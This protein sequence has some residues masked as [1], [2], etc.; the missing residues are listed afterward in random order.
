MQDANVPP[1]DQTPVTPPSA[2]PRFVC[3]ICG[4][5]SETICSWCA[6][7]A[8]GNHVC[9]GCRRCSDCCDCEQ[10]PTTG[11]GGARGES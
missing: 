9:E 2:V 7:D 11:Q 4:E 6:K 8:C 5:P 1:G 3:S 10:R